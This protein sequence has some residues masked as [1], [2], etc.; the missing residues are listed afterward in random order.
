M[1]ARSQADR[2]ATLSRPGELITIDAA[3]QRVRVCRR[4]IYNWIRLGRV[5]TV[6]TAGGHYR[7]YADSLVVEQVPHG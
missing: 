4:T 7:I 3:C 2:V 6:R 1:N 5:D